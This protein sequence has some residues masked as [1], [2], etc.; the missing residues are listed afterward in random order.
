MA[1]AGTIGWNDFVSAQAETLRQNGKRCIVLW[2]RGGPSQCETFSP[3]IGHANA[4]E[5]KSIATT[6]PGIQ[7]ADKLPYLSRVMDDLC[8]IRSMTSKEGSHPR[9]TFLMQTGYLPNPSARHPALGS[10]VSQQLGAASDLPNFVQIGGGGR[11]G[12]SSGLLGADFAPFQMREA[13]RPP[14]NVAPA[15]SDRRFLQRLELMESLDRQYARRG[16]RAEVAG[17]RQTARRAASMMRSKELDA[18]AL[19]R[20]P[21]SVKDAYGSGPFAEGCLLARRL[22]ESGVTFVQVDLGNWDTHQDNFAKTTELCGA[23]DQPYAALLQ[24]LR[25]RGLLED[26]LVLWMGEFGRTP[27]VN[28]RGGRDHFPRAFSVALSGCG[29]QGGQV[30]G[31]TSRDGM[32]VTDRPVTVPDLFQT[33]CLALGMDPDFENMAAA[34]RPIKVVEGGTPVKEIFGSA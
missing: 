3:V 12:V 2:M 22:I 27:R 23:L 16:G 26:T 33:I 7:I 25:S 18:F 15:T 21:A 31:A 10:V 9:A 29:I 8:I 30:I 20:E 34:G 6:V 4:G 1:A 19:D 13:S 24:D 17:H 28:P 5:T 11:G 32:E 14:E